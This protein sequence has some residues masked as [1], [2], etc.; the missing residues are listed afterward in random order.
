[1][2]PQPPLVHVQVTDLVWAC[3]VVPCR[4]LVLSGAKSGQALESRGEAQATFI[5]EIP[6]AVHNT[7]IRHDVGSPVMGYGGRRLCWAHTYKQVVWE[8]Y[9]LQLITVPTFQCCED[10]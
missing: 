2:A 9:L 10:I 3:A 7:N 6:K 5:A 8:R 4:S 1:M